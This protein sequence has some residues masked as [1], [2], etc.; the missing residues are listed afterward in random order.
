L[1]GGVIVRKGKYKLPKTVFEEPKKAKTV[2]KMRIGTPDKSVFRVR[3]FF[4]RLKTR[5]SRAL[6]V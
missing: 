5:A 1:N 2:P 4:F 3:F 6:T